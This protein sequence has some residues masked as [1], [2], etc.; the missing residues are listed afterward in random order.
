M[1]GNSDAKRLGIASE[2]L[3]PSRLLHGLGG[4]AIVHDE[5]AS[6]VFSGD[7]GTQ[8]AHDVDLAVLDPEGD[9][10]PSLIGRNVFGNWRF[11]YSQLERRLAAEVIRCD[12]TSTALHW[13]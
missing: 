13:E 10:I 4:S 12:R 1:L 3:G 8:Y 2:R 6:L 7:N 9:A 5:R 11:D